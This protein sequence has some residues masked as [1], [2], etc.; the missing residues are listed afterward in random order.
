MSMVFGTVEIPDLPE[1]PPTTAEHEG[2]MEKTVEPEL[3]AETDKEMFKETEGAADED[4]TETK[5]AMIDAVVQASL[6]NS[7][8]AVS[9]GAGSSRM[10]LGNE[11][12]VQTDTPSTDAQIDGATAQTG[13]PF[14]LHLFLYF[15][16]PLDIFICI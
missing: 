1:M 16:S 12:Q 7:L 6:E 11:T 9:S 13:S 14:Y 3:E 4:L 15:F 8:F 10:T 5:A 2:R